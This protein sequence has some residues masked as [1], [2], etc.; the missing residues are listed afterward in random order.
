MHIFIHLP[1][2]PY[3]H[4]SFNHLF[5]ESYYYLHTHFQFYYSTTILILFLLYLIFILFF[6]FSFLP[7]THLYSTLISFLFYSSASTSPHFTS[8]PLSF[9]SI[10]LS[11]TQSNIYT[12]YYT[13]VL[14]V[15]QNGVLAEFEARFE[16]LLG[17]RYTPMLCLS[18]CLIFISFLLF[19]FTL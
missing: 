8:H 7:F 1:I 3:L 14:T 4:T 6:F 16:R 18:Y 9:S 15:V 2:H 10:P 11:T 13:T 17:W 19:N 5:I 12:T